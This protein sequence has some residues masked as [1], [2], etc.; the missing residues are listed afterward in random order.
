MC[1]GFM[2][3]LVM[4]GN[5]VRI[6]TE[7]TTTVVHRLTPLGGQRLVQ[8]ECCGVVLGLTIPSS[9][10]WLFATSTIRPIG[11]TTLDFDVCQ[12]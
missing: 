3:W 11:P 12:D 10:G 5:I 2:T 6:G 8:E 7:R 9:Y 4:F 1:M